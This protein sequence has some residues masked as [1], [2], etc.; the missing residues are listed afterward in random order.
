M[1]KLVG[2]IARKVFDAEGRIETPAKGKHYFWL[3][4]WLLSE[5]PDPR[6][7]VIGFG[8]ANIGLSELTY[9]NSNL[10]P[11]RRVLDATNPFVYD[12]ALYF[13]LSCSSRC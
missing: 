9:A 11:R 4:H 5:T 12:L 13:Y 3:R 2:G 7:P 6:P 8:G 1:V 10:K